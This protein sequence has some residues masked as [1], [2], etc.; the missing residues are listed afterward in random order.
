MDSLD[1]LAFIRF[2]LWR[3]GRISLLMSYLRSDGFSIHKSPAPHLS[4]C[5]GLQ[6]CFTSLGSSFTTRKRRINHKLKREVLQQQFIIMEQRLWTIITWPAAILTTV[7]GYYM[8]YLLDLWESGW[9]MV[10]LGLTTAFVGISYHESYSI[11]AIADETRLSWTST[12]LRLWNE[13]A[14]MFLVTIIFV[15]VSKESAWIGFMALWAFF[16]LGITLMIAIRIYKRL[17]REVE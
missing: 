6:G 8:V 16:A 14:A 2:L 12:Q 3:K 11:Q 13:L 9:M 10:K 1:F 17:S 5:R 7:F 4:W 15:V